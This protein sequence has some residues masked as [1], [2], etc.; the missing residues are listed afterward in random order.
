MAD[1]INAGGIDRLF[2]GQRVF[3]KAD[4]RNGVIDRLVIISVSLLGILEELRADEGTLVIA[5]DGDS[6]TR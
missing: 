5:Q 1:D 6:T 3:H 4:G 2:F